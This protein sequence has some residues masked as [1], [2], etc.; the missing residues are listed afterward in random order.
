MKETYTYIDKSIFDRD[1]MAWWEARDA[2][3]KADDVIYERMAALKG[4]TILNGMY[5]FIG[6]VVDL[7]GAVIQQV[8]YAD[9]EFRA[10]VVLDRD[11]PRIEGRV[12]QMTL[13]EL[14]RSGAVPARTAKEKR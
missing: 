13:V 4:L 5:S 6:G 12:I 7:T 8:I 10:Y 14:I 9:D 2:L 1:V 3:S 11:H